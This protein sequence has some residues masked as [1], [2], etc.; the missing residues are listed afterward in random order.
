[1]RERGRV[2]L[3]AALLLSVV[4]LAWPVPAS[5]HDTTASGPFRLRLGWADE[6]P[7]SGSKN[8]VQVTVTTADARPVADVGGA[9]TVEVAF[10]ADRVVLPLAP[11]GRP[12][13]VQAALVPTRAGTYAFHVTGAIEGQSIDA[14]S[15]CSEETFD[16]VADAAEIQFPA[17]DPPTGLVA[18]RIE[19]DLRR[20]EESR[21]AASTA[22]RLSTAAV[23]LAAVA[24]AVGGV[25]WRRGARPR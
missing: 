10:G 5:A 16:C 7:F 11:T 22:R 14:S 4:A 9:L 21:T 23:A 17:K 8:S 1:M 19:R 3:S 6:P 13:E 18:A 20:A 2:R 12:G 15:T 24:L 25:A